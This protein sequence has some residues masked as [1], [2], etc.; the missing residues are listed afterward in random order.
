MLIGGFTNCRR[1]VELN[2]RAAGTGTTSLDPILM[3]PTE[4]PEQGPLPKDPQQLVEGLPMWNTCVLC[5]FI[6]CNGF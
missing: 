4:R 1:A 2:L 3:V 5:Y 6:N